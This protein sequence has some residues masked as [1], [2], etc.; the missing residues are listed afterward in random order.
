MSDG[1]ESGEFVLALSTSHLLHRA[2]QLAADRFAKLVG[3]KGVTLRQFAVLAAIHEAPGLNQTELVRITGIDR[4]TLADMIMRMEKRG[5]IARSASDADARANDVR[6][7]NAGLAILK[8][9]VQSAKAADAAILDSL[10]KAKRKA[11]Q[12][13]LIKLAEASDKAAEAAEKKARK[14]ARR[15]ARVEARE[16]VKAEKRRMRLEAKAEADKKKRKAEPGE[17][18]A[19]RAGRSKAARVKPGPA[20]D[21]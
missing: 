1:S 6:L 9:A 3:D 20:V 11:F 18:A 8:S 10:P 2:Q 19:P 17:E 7:T 5:W 16:R 15:K 21:S 12:H 13:T 14:E 4:S